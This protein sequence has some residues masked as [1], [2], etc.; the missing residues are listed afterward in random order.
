M[1]SSFYPRLILMLHS[2]RLRLTLMFMLV[3]MVAVGTVALIA[4]QATTNNL[5]VYNQAKDNQQIIST[6]LAAYQQH[7]SQQ[8]LQALTEQ[9][10]HASHLRLILLDEQNRVIADSDHTLI[11][12]VITS[13]VSSSP[14]TTSSSH[15]DL[16]Y[17]STNKPAQSSAHVDFQLSNNSPEATFLTS[18]NHAL[19]M[20]VLIA[21]LLALLLALG[22]ASTLL[23]PLHTLK[24]AAGRMEQGDLSQRVS[25]TA[26]GEI[27]ALAHAFNTMADSLSRSEQVRSNLMNDVAH[28]L[29][30]PLMNIRGS[31]ELLAD[32]ILEPTPETLASLYE[33]TSLLSRLVSDLQ[34][35][36]LAEAGQ[37]RLARQPIELA[38][39]VSQTVQIVQPQL[40]RKH[41]MLCVSLPSHLPPVEA[42]PERVAQILRNLLSNAIMHTTP[43]GKITITASLSAAM[44]QIRVLDTGE[45]IAPEHLPYLFDRFYRADSSRSRATGGTGLGLAIVKQM[46]QAHGG[47]ITVESQPGKGTCFT[48][49]LPAVPKSPD[50]KGSSQVALISTT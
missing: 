13:P 27:G 11:G 25:I 10:A 35:L 34:D 19:W 22:F 29:R 4:N 37:L 40:E 1:L 8:T 14:S 41:L 45:G 32:Q 12:Q 5:Q 44:V 31:L 7:Q 6:L 43:P 2:L 18:V 20:A 48:F 49:S 36:S 3:V 47:Q 21:G 16:L 15:S 24:A 38:E 26:K 50:E 46:I 23:K 17:I 28:E 33:E 39:V 30:N 42:D 9:L